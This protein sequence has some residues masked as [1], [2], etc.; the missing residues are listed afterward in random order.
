M[1]RIDGIIGYHTRLIQRT[2]ATTISI[3]HHKEGVVVNKQPTNQIGQYNLYYYDF[4]PRFSGTYLISWDHAPAEF[5]WEVLDVPHL[6]LFDLYSD[7]EKV[8]LEVPGAK[9][10]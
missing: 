1:V 7:L 5:R 6:S 4:V 2:R 8:S 9:T 3:I 10:G